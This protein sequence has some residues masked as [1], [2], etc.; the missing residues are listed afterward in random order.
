MLA[1]NLWRNQVQLGWPSLE[2][3][4]YPSKKERLSLIP[5]RSDIGL[6]LQELRAGS[7]AAKLQDTVMIYE[8]AK[9]T[10]IALLLTNELM[11]TSCS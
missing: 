6:E 4:I 8:Y 9:G 5:G 1:Q 3:S 11:S 7:S 2:Q 10:I